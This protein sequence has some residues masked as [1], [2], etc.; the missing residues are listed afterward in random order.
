MKDESDMKRMFVVIVSLYLSIG[1]LLVVSGIPNQVL[2]DEDPSEDWPMFRL[3]WQHTGSKDGPA[4]VTNE[5]GW[6]FDTNRFGSYQWVV[7]SPVI[8]D[9]YV[10]IGCDNGK[11]YKL[12]IRCG[13][14]IWNYPVRDE[15]QRGLFWSSPYVDRKSGM[16]FVHANGVHAVDMET[17]ERIWHFETET[18]EFSSPV[19]YE[20]K[21]YIGSHDQHLYCLPQFDPNGDGIIDDDEI[22]WYYKT[23]EYKAGVLLDDTGGAISCTVA[24]A[25]GKLFAAEQT[26]YTDWRNYSDYHVIALP[27]EEPSGNGIMD[28]DE[29]IWKYKIGEKVPIVEIDVPVQGCEAF[30]SPTICEELGMLYI[31]TTRE[32]EPLK[33]FCALSLE[34]DQ[35]GLDNDFDGIIDNEGDLRWRFMTNRSVF[36]TPSINGG[37]IFFG[38]GEYGS[39][40]GDDET[41]PGNVYALPKEDPNGDGIISP[42]EIIWFYEHDHGILSSPLVADGMVFIG[43]NDGKILCFNEEIGN[44]IWEYQVPGA[45]YEESF[46]S[47]PSLYQGQVVVGNC[48]GKVYS[49]F[50]AGPNDA[51]EISISVPTTGDVVGGLVDISGNATDDKMVARVEVYIHK[52]WKSD[53]AK[54]DHDLAS[55]RWNYSW[56]SSSVSNGTYDI[57]IRAYD[58]LHFSEIVTIMVNVTQGVTQGGSQGDTQGDVPSQDDDNGKSGW[59]IISRV[60]VGALLVLVVI[61]FVSRK[62][63]G[64]AGGENE[65]GI[66]CPECG[67]GA[68]YSEEY[69]DYYCWECEEYIGEME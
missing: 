61:V 6:I 17:G 33:G 63:R 37:V 39:E 23:G 24:I 18:I 26:R 42:N 64:N 11:L 57:S 3:N 69:E 30:S 46:G 50:P 66:E 14:E 28:H 10:Y 36:S 34:P 4:P 48:N 65:A 13:A 54:A 15:G 53:W 43:S 45:L 27:L 5:T 59:D 19:V 12:D 32:T 16:V 40:R 52:N 60:G 56:D 31:G 21:V 9:G 7:S 67:S 29:I 20:G 22:I 62:G 41:T 35:D 2:A 44:P 8:V 51:P 68:E 25:D 47:S 55:G 49:F 38:T 58:G 1:M